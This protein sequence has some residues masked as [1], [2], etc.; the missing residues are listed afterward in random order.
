MMVATTTD[1]RTR[2]GVLILDVTV[3]E[4]LGFQ[5]EVSQYPVESGVTI[6]DH[7]TQGAETLRIS[8]FVATQD[9][10][11]FEA[12][13]TGELKVVDV[14]ESLRR[15]HA[16]RAV[17]EVSTGQV[18]YA[19]MAFTDLRAVRSGDAGQGNFFQI[20][21]ELTKVRKVNL[22][23]AEVPAER[24]SAQDGAK[25]RS[26]QTNKPGGNA[27]R[28]GQNAAGKSGEQFGPPAPRTS[29]LEML[30]QGGTPSFLGGL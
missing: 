24:V 30:R 20:T 14:V 22:K 28:A 10:G 23:T 26:G 13:D 1:R 4:E 12:S 6:S 18:R 25:G 27:G 11:S 17:L 16:D 3:T 19:D 8:G 9:V 2:L 5:A 29:T 7:V 21:G 15:I